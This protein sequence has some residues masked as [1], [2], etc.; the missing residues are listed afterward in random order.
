M[1]AESK[2]LFT[3]WEAALREFFDAKASLAGLPLDLR[4]TAFQVAVWRFLQ[5]V[6]AGKTVTYAEV[7]AAVG[8]PKAVRAVASACAHNRIALA[9]PCHRV[10]RGDGT[11][12][13]YRWG[14]ERKQSLL[15]LERDASRGLD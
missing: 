14:M 5:S 15:H 4:G 10:I 8:R 13:G 9:V 11:L 3:Q 2:Q 6:P 1:P 12:A 7:A